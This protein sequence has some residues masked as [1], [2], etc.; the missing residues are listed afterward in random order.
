MKAIARLALVVCLCAAVSPA[1][2]PAPQPVNQGEELA[3]VEGLTGR[4]GGHI[5]IGQRSEPKTLNPVTATDAVSREVFERLHADLIAINRSTQKTEPALAKSW[6]MSPDGRTF[7]LKLRKG[8]R[9]S[10]GHPFDADDVV[11]SFTVYLDEAVGAPQRDLL[12][13]DGK[14]LTISKLDQYTVCVSLPRPY[15]AAER[16]FDSFAILPRHILEKPYREGKFVQAWPLNTPP[17]EVVGLGPFRVKQYW[18][19]QRI[20]LERNPYYWKTDRENHRLPYLDELVFLFVGSEDAQVMR[21]EAGETDLINRLSSENY[22]LL[23]KEQSARRSQL[24]DLGPSLEYNF[25]VFNLNDLSG[26]KLDSIS[27]KQAWFQDLKFRQAVSAAVDRDS[28]VKLVYGT[29]GTALWG[30]VGPGNKMWVNQSIPHPQRSLETA[31]QL[32][33]SAGFTWNASGQLLDHNGQPVEFSIATSSSNAQRM[34]M[35]TLLQY[36]LSHLGMQVHVVPLDF[37]AMIDRVF[38]SFD[39]EAAIMG[40]GGGDADP[41]PEMNVWMSSG[42]THLWRMNETQPATAWEREIDQLMNEQMITLDY[43]KRKKLY[44]RV[45]QIISE[46]LPFIFLATPNILTGAKGEIGNF[47]P[48]LLDHYTLWNADQLYLRNAESAGVR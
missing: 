14:P 28:I 41:N 11:F 37:R 4:Y 35:A 32:L 8:I 43:H 36:D 34:K 30:N 2:T 17:T 6:K 5:V 23:S 39:Y 13:I 33:K 16:L 22:A 26:K 31:R 20:L 40:L 45:Q 21:F 9:F 25:L 29:R 27:R 48:A 38:Q 47:Q 3:R 44:D 10:D 46:Q 15:A 7:T 19:G 42:G 1:S 18:P 12:L 24:A